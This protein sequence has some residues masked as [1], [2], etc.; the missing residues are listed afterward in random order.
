[1]RGGLARHGP[2]MMAAVAVAL[3]FQFPLSSLWHGS[4]YT[5]SPQVAADNAAMA[6]VPDGATVQTTLNLLAP[7]AAR[8]DTFWIGNA[9]NPLTQYIVFDGK[10]SGYSPAPANVP[11]FIAPAL[12]DRRLPADLRSHRRLRLPPLAPPPPPPPPPQPTTTL[13]R[14]PPPDDHPRPPMATPAGSD[15]PRPG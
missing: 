14:R 8:T 6:V 7:L 4:T 1:M 3:A 5:I 12:P 13:P 9:G 2:A 10:N 11:A 15:H